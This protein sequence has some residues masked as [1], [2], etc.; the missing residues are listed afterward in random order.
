MTRVENFLKEMSLDKDYIVIIMTL[1]HM[2]LK[3]IGE[4]S[5][6][7]CSNEEFTKVV[8]FLMNIEQKGSSP[9]RRLF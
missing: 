6:S 4:R 2:Y 5:Q 7:L 1:L 9:K 8:T 3:L